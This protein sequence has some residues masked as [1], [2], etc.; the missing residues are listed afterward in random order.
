MEPI[1]SVKS[2][3]KLYRIYHR[4]IDRLKQAIWRGKKQFY[5]PVWA[6]KD[7]SFD[8]KKGEVFGII[9]MNGAGKTT[10]LQILA[11]ILNPTI[12]KITTNGKILNLIELGSGINFEYSG[13]ENILQYGLILGQ[14]K[15]HIEA[16]MEEA[17]E[18]ADIG[19]FI[20]QPIK[21]YS[22]G[23]IMRLAFS[24]ITICKCDILLVDEIIGVG[25]MNFRM[26]CFNWLDSFINKGGTLCI[27]S[28]D[29][30]LIANQCH[31]VA[32][33]NQGKLVAIGNPRDVIETFK[34][35][36]INSHHKI[37]FLNKHISESNIENGK[38][39]LDTPRKGNKKGL[40]TRF[41]IN[42]KELGE[43]IVLDINEPITI[44]IEAVFHNKFK[45]YSFCF[46]LITSNGID[47]FSISSALTDTKHPEL[48]PDKP[49]TCSITVN[50]NLQPGEYFIKPAI[51]DVR[52]TTTAELLD[53][54]ESYAKIIVTGNTNT[55]GFVEF[56]HSIKFY[57]QW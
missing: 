46:A 3:S 56:P 53:V 23:M 29:V 12:G 43:H 33:L 10:L 41:L 31:R 24:V 52:G 9:G 55:Y 42:Q 36:S 17:I 34:H 2:I 5:T 30:S 18:F 13:R 15:K 27:V 57:E 4:P 48:I 14:S 22:T 20:D 28:H 7:I 35:D 25:D 40:I 39:P 54:L 11:G 19:D 51:T 16:H 45:N 21:T 50:Q 44:E 49:V 47:I 38:I 26:K 1:I 37:G 32:F 8:I 6:L